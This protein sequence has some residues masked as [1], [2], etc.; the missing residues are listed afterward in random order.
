MAVA[1]MV[2]VF[3]CGDYFTHYCLFSGESEVV[4]TAFSFDIYP[5]KR[6][7]SFIS[8]QKVIHRSLKLLSAVSGNNS[9]IWL[10]FTRNSAENSWISLGEKGILLMRQGRLAIT[11]FS[12]DW[13][14]G[15][16]KKCR[17]SGMQQNNDQAGESWLIN[18]V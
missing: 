13:N 17:L 9:I 14:Q 7:D 5:C 12:R 2:A 4:R 11:V 18:Q 3:L 15:D 1:H 6:P 8:E 10:D 16:N